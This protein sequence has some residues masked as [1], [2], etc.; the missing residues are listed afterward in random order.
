MLFTPFKDHEIDYISIW[1]PAVDDD[2]LGADGVKEYLETRKISML[3]IR[4][5]MKPI[6]WK[7]GPIDQYSLQYVRSTCPEAANGNLVG[8][9]FSYHLCQIGIR[10]VKDMHEGA[11][12]FDTYKDGMLTRVSDDFI[13]VIPPDMANELGMLIYSMSTAPEEIKKKSPS[14][15]ARKNSKSDTPAKPV[16]K[17]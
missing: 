4:E 2:A 1:D 14:R 15:S 3:P 8:G 10:G 13:K 9:V 6:T 17:R 5:G 7:I 11:P 16:R 12:T